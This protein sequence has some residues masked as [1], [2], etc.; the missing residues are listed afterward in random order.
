MSCDESRQGN[1]DAHRRGVRLLSG[2]EDAARTS[3]VRGIWIGSSRP[4]PGS[5]ASHPG[6][7]VCAHFTAVTR[8][9]KEA[10]GILS[11]RLSITESMNGRAT[12]LEKLARSC[13]GVLLL[14]WS[15]SSFRLQGA[16]ADVAT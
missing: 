10:F 1:H 7:K 12:L 16:V 2:L 13:P 3:R 4:G 6:W 15:S 8:C 11:R 9:G 5:V 14:V